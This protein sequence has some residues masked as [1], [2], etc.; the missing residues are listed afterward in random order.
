M[1]TLNYSRTLWRS[2]LP[3][4]SI[5]RLLYDFYF[6]MDTLHIYYTTLWYSLIRQS[7]CCIT[8]ANV[9]VRYSVQVK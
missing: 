5:T 2:D 8:F 9:V 3:A 4:F 7:F 1:Y 6:D